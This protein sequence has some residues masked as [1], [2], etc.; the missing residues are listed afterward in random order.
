MNI[1]VTTDSS[2]GILAVEAEK[3]EVGFLPIPIIID[4]E[5]YYEGVNITPADVYAALESD[6]RIT[7]S[8]P[9]PQSLRD[10][11]DGLLDT[12]CEKILHLPITSALSSSYATAAAL[13][14]EYDGRVR[15]VNNNRIS[16]PLREAVKSALRM[17][18]NGMNAD[19]I[20]DRL[21]R[22]GENYSVYITV[23]TLEYLQKSG[24]I[25]AFTAQMGKL[26]GIKPV[27]SIRKGVISLYSKQRGMKKSKKEMFRS[28]AADVKTRFAGLDKNRMTVCVAGT[29]VDKKE[30]AEIKDTLSEMFPG[31][32]VCYDELPACIGCHTGG[33]AV[34]IGVCFDD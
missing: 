28:L 18:K 15:V 22:D 25:S 3:M 9:S 8:Q 7:T 16:V 26:F 14:K 32:P 11:W 21:E 2:S 34:G 10:L 33:G 1:A 20:A 4:G 12:G 17:V 6:K 30:I 23:D 13:S 24:R 29:C 5:T 19:E 31:R 27:L